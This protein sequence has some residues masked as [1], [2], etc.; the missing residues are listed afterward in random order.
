M[1]IKYLIFLKPIL[2]VFD[3]SLKVQPKI[4]KKKKK[5]DAGFGSE[6]KPAWVSIGSF[7]MALGLNHCPPSV[8]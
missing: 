2:F 1:Q 7:K 8:S 4:L 6:A 3:F 5:K